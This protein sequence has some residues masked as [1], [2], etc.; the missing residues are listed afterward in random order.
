MWAYNRDGAR[1]EGLKGQDED[2]IREKAD[3]SRR[4]PL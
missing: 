3:L 2:P 4:R 1:K